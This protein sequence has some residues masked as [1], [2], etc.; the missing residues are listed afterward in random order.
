MLYLLGLRIIKILSEKHI[1]FS[2]PQ[3]CSTLLVQ[4]K[5]KQIFI[6]EAKS[7]PNKI[8]RAA[9]VLKWVNLFG[10]SEILMLVFKRPECIHSFKKY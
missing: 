1:F 6:K 9:M 8:L 2:L 10:Q 4:W 7:N 3:Y 5:E